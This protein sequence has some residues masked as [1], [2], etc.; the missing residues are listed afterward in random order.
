[1]A[2]IDRQ[3][4]L[5]EQVLE[6][7][8]KRLLDG[9]LRPG[10]RIKEAALAEE[11]GIS[12]APIREACRALHQAGLL[13]ILP[14][15]GVV[16]RKIS[17]A[18]VLALFDIRAALWR[19]AGRQAAGNLTRRD[20][21]RMR[22]LIGLM[23]G[24]ARA[25]DVDRYLE[26]N[27]EFHERIAVLSGNR[28]LLRLQRELF[29]QARLFRRR[30][31]DWDQHLLERNEAHKAILDALVTGD[32]ETAGELSEEHAL[33]SKRRFVRAVRAAPDFDNGLLMLD[34][35]DRLALEQAG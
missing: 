7:L 26:L 34:E 17:L 15:R 27:T 33:M 23:D 20:A 31:L 30:G 16:V 28:P 10:D 9:S 35:A 6:L 29:M 25:P 5:Q 2:A 24:A 21:D 3:R 14:N 12:R 22:E 18:D 32:V 19:L 1:M 8:E 4:P 11:W 13:D